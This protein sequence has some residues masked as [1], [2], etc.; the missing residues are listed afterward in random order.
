[1]PKIDFK[2][3]ELFPDGSFHFTDYTF[4]GDESTGWNILRAGKEHLKLGPGY[5]PVNVIF[6]GVCSTDLA[7]IYLPYPLPQIIGHEVVGSVDGKAVVV[8]IN[9]SHEARGHEIESCPFCSSGLPTQCPDRITLGINLLPGGFAPYLLAP[10]NAIIPLPE[11]M[12][13]KGAALMEPF[14]A[15]LHAVD[16]FPPG[17]DDSIAVIGPRRLGS[18]IIAALDARRNDSGSNYH[19]T[20]IV[21]RPDLVQLCTNMGADEVIDLSASSNSN[22]GAK[23]SLIAGSFDIVYDTTGSPE[24][25]ETALA[26]SKDTVHLKSTTGRETSGMHRLTDMVV[27]EI[28]LLPYSTEAMNFKWERDS[29]RKNLAVY[30]SPTFPEAILGKIRRENPGKSFHRMSI[31]NAVDAIQSN[32]GFPNEGFLP[33]FDLALVSS[34]AEADSVIRPDPS[35]E[36]SILRPGGAIIFHPDH[37]H[38]RQ[39]ALSRAILERKIRILTSRCGD[40]HR[41]IEVLE[42]DPE[43]LERIEENMITHIF[44]LRQIDEAFREAADGTSSIKVLV[45]GND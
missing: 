8:E 40:F 15:A 14:A 31:E 44:D 35:V 38:G 25:F 19:I 3:P 41:A 36:F 5:K 10:V 30:V 2:A 32:P 42:T 26:L 22:S 34:F 17:K 23:G 4:E 39:T 12:S 6:C 21:R 43:V 7:R 13:K 24:G 1:M 11:S 18:L 20:G 37:F 9:S 45:K 16:S 29:S 28:S 33:R 27:D